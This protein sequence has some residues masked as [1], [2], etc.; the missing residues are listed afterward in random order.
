MGGNPAT[1][2]GIKIP[3]KTVFKMRVAKAAKE[4]IGPAR[5]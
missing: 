4:A 5:K 3:A 1:G 2:A